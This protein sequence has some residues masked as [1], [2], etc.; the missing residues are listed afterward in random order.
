MLDR[1]RYRPRDAATLLV[2]IVEL[3]QRGLSPRDI[4]DA[5]GLTENAVRQLLGEPLPARERAA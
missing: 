2:A 4:A 1:D 5:L 3:R